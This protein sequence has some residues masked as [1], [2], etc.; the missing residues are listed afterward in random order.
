MGD[1]AVQVSLSIR[2]HHGEGPLWD[3]ATAR[4][5][6]VD[7][8]G[9]RVHCFD[10]QS[11]NDS[12]WS[13]SGQPGGVV[14]SAAGE[15]VVASPEGLAVL[16]RST[17]T[18]DLRVPIEQDRPENRA[19]DAKVD[20]RGRAWVGTMAF[21]KRARNAALYRVDGGQVSRVADGLTICNGP[22]FDEPQGRLYLA[23]TA[24]MVVDVFDLDPATG[25]IDRRRRFLDFSDAQVWPDG[26]T[27]DDEGMLWVA[28]GRAGAVHRYR[29]DGTL[30]GV[31][32]V[33][34]SNP[35]SVAFGGIDGGDLYITTSWFDLE[36]DS[37]NAQPLAGLIFRCRPGV[38]GP[39]SPR[40]AG[41]PPPPAPLPEGDPGPRHPEKG[42]IS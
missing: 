28:L 29:P 21:D 32:E 6:W 13:T 23:D 2:A 24:I 42:G 9:Q 7:I 33:P 12:S 3:A 15:P 22:A 20:G 41:V 1:I 37:R 8:T 34:T 39:P 25:A 11:S 38:T 30:D 40:Y 19:N 31:V 17:G 4:L 16:D 27:V 14:L 5:W 26:M 18:M 35:T 10:P 36:I